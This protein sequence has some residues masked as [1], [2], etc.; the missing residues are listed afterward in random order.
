MDEEL[1]AVIGPHPPLPFPNMRDQDHLEF[2]PIS[3]D[4]II[5][6]SVWLDPISVHIT[7]IELLGAK[8]PVDE[9]VLNA[10]RPERLHLPSEAN[11]AGE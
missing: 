5:H 8:A 4:A 6:A 7:W 1:H 2:D 11:G 9:D 3:I 10:S